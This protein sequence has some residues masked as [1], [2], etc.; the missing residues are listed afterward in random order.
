MPFNSNPAPYDFRRMVV[1]VIY[2]TFLSFNVI[3]L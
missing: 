2:V 1:Y 3:G